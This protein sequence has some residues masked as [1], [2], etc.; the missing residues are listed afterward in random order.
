M[1]GFEPVFFGIFK[2]LNLKT[3]YPGPLDDIDC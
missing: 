2:E 1:T 3:E